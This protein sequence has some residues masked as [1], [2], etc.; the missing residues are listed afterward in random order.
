MCNGC[1]GGGSISSPQALA[2]RCGMAA[3]VATAAAAA[4]AAVAAQITVMPQRGL[5]LSSPSNALDVQGKGCCLSSANQVRGYKPEANGCRPGAELEQ[6]T[7]RGAAVGLDSSG[8]AKF[9]NSWLEFFNLWSSHTPEYLPEI[10]LTL[11]LICII[12]AFLNLHL[13]NFPIPIPVILFLLGCSTEILSF[14]SNQVQTYVDPIQS[15]SPDLF[16]GLFIPVIF[17][18]AAFDMDVYM[19]QKLFWQ[20]LVII[21]PGLLIN[22]ILIFWYLASVDKIVLKHT[23]WLLFST[24]LVCTDPMLTA[25][26]LRHLGLSRSLTTLI[27]GESLFTSVI[28][29]IIFSSI[30]DRTLASQSETPHTLAYDIAYGIGSYFMASILF[31]ILSSKLIQLWLS[32]VFGDDVNHMSIIF[33]ILYLIFYFCELVKM[34]GIFTLTIMGLFLNSTNFKPGVEALL[35]KF[36]NCLSFVAFLMVFTFTGLIIPA[37]VYLYVTLSD[38]YYSLNIYLTLIVLRLLVFLLMSP[39]LSRVGHQFTWRWAFIMVWSEKKGMPNIGMAFLLAYSDLFLASEK[40]K[41]QIVFHGVSVCLITLTVN[42]F[43]LP[44]AATKLGLRHVTS[45]KYNTFQHFQELTKSTASAL[46]LD[47]NLAG[48]DWNMIEKGIILENPY[49]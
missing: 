45:P 15:M 36:W 47:K 5:Q 4:A 23:P 42:R 10:F 12:G 26:A 41:A 20:I 16:F 38:I 11:S 24:L 2:V 48:A 29:L 46:K 13:K 6:E 31:G 37:H 40:E 49:A 3:A 30:V 39:I 33:S 14:T 25:A 27:N 8:S 17:F 34:S 7:A 9:S 35:L 44:I 19:L 22:Y 28:S 32:A 43:I 21:I 1:L 18:N